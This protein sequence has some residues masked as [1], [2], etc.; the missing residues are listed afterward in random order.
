MALT[1]CEEELSLGEI[2]HR[3][4][5]VTE[6]LDLTDLRGEI[7]MR[8]EWRKRSEAEE[9]PGDPQLDWSVFWRDTAG[10]RGAL[11]SAALHDA[12]RLSRACS[13][14]VL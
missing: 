12:R 4:G 10:A 8:T 1:G 14:V 9:W 7:R 6:L 11:R 5:V 2:G 3:T 13:P